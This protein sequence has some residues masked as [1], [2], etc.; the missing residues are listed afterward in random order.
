M[1]EFCNVIWEIFMLA[2]GRIG[3]FLKGCDGLLYVLIVFVA[4]DY[5]TSIM[6]AV[7]DKKLSSKVGIQGICGKILIFAM[8]EMGYLLDMHVIGKGGV[9]RTVILYFYI[10]NEG[11]SLIENVEYL[12]LPIPSKLYKVL[13]Q[14]HDREEKEGEG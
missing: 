3:N 2:G 1:K 13:R 6:C 10:S 11:L 7:A 9:F 5:I 8:V 12:G 14:L 4:L